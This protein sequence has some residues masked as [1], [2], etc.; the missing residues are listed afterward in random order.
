[1]NTTTPTPRTDL[2][3]EPIIN[4]V[5]RNC[6]HCDGSGQLDDGEN[7]IAKVCPKHKAIWDA[8]EAVSKLECELAEAKADLSVTRDALYESHA[9]NINW[10]KTAEA[11]DLEYF[12]ECRKVMKRAESVLARLL[13]KDI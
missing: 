11:S 7:Y 5:N 13:A 10:S 4:F 6:P 3:R 12:S 2:I 1:M 9:L 8:I